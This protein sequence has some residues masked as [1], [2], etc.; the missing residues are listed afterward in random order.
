MQFCAFRIVKSLATLFGLVGLSNQL[1]AQPAA[2]PDEAKAAGKQV[3]DFPMAEF[4]YFRDMDMV[5]DPNNSQPVAPKRLA[6]DLDE[7]KGR[8][9][10]V[11]WCGGNEWF[12]DWLDQHS[13]GF[14]DFLKLV[15]FLSQ[16]PKTSHY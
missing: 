14:L 10:W 9:T 6:L 5:G 4:D 11:M 12:W 8:N 7:I 2:P 13:Y 1:P 16:R 15:R 3:A